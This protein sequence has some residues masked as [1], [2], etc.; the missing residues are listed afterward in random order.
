MDERFEKIKDDDSAYV[1]HTYRRLPVAFVKGL[2]TRLWDTAGT[3]YL[4]LVGGLG[5]T[6]LGHCH[7][8]VTEAIREQAGSLVHTTNLYY[9]EPQAELARRLVESSFE[10]RCFFC[11][12]G[13]EANEGALKLAR[14]YHFARGK[15]R[16]KFVCALQS[17]HGRTLTTL[18]ATGQPAKWP[19][20]APVTPGFAHVP[21]N[22][23]G[24]LLEAV[25][26]ETAA[27][28]LEPVQGESGVHPASPEFMKAA[29]EACDRT[30]ALLV[31]D[32]VQSG[33]GRTGS[34]FAYEQL[35]VVPDVMTL[36]KGLA[37][38][39]P[40]GAFVAR[41]E[42]AEVLEPGDHGST[43]GGGF[44]ACAAANATL[45]AIIS[46]ELALNARAV[47]KTLIDGLNSIAEGSPLVT[48]VRGRGLMVAAE[49]SGG[50]ARDVVTACL[51]R[52]VILND[53]TASAV[54]MLP[55]LI[56]SEGDAREGLAV[57]GDVLEEMGGPRG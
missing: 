15:P 30:G 34:L 47:G 13:A 10:G 50:F 28:L 56:L 16:G 27:V 26:D 53:V 25:D 48:E 23:V 52:G 17:F 29:R 4:D 35:G 45:E 31:L 57:L 46:G 5:A 22:D 18:S 51:S 39:V 37:N 38:G 41:D 21:L 1:M 19:P 11:N 20:F 9:I 32:E 42:F 40:I 55:P 54:R 2:G 49:L 3:E 44:L 8:A 12:S 36:A 6:P 33:L 24:A 7:P 14:K 43:F